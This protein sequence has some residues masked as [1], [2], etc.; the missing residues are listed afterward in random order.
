MAFNSP[1]RVR[2]IALASCCA[3]MAW[4]P[5]AASPGLS[6]SA[7]AT[8]SKNVSRTGEETFVDPRRFSAAGSRLNPK[9]KLAAKT[10][11]GRIK[12]Y[13]F[14]IG[15]SCRLNGATASP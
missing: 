11:V 2:A 7:S 5:A 13:D 9:H 8:A 14:F 1:Q 6:L 4:C 10:K 12:L 15:F 3:A